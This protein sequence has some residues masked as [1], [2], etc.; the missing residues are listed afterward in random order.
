MK[1]KGME[2]KFRIIKPD[3]TIDDNQLCSN[4]NPP[5]FNLQY[6]N[7]KSFTKSRTTF[8]RWST[9]LYIAVWKNFK[10]QEINE[11]K[12]SCIGRRKSLIHLEVGRLPS[13][14]DY[15]SYPISYF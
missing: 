5:E 1:L 14:P 6:N 11:E 12:L 13:R 9:C 7:F 10:G 3:I 8:T 2:I 15:E 4:S